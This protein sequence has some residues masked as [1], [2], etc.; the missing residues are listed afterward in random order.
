MKLQR[1]G[2]RAA[3]S[4]LEMCDFGRSYKGR[5][6]AAPTDGRPSFIVGRSYDEVGPTKIFGGSARF[7]VSVASGKGNHYDEPSTKF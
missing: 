1:E 7:F 3:V 5:V 2:K 6:V 4:S